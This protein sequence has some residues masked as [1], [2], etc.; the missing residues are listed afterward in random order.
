[1]SDV[2][3]EYG[4]RTQLYKVRMKCGHIEQRRMRPATAGIPWIPWTPDA[5]VE[6]PT[7]E[8]K[9]CRTAKGQG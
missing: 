8:C 1:M 5:T 2:I 4:E 6:A 9:A 3:S 7:A